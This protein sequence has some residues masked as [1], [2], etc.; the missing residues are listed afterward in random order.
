MGKHIT[1]LITGL[2]KGGAETMLY[3]L[4]CN[5][6]DGSV[7]NE[8][9]SL[10]CSHYYEPLIRTLGVKIT[11]VHIKAHPIRSLKRIIR[12][13]KSADTVY[14]WMY[15]A[16]LLGYCIG[17]LVHVPNIVWSIHHSNLDPEFNKKST[18]AI[19]KICASLSHNVKHIVYAGN[20][21][22]T[23]HEA[24][25]YDKSRGEC[26]DNGCDIE[27]YKHIEDARGSLIEE[28]SID[29]DCQII[30]SIARSHPIK[31]I[32][33][34]I[35]AFGEVHMK[36]EKAIAVLCGNGVDNENVQLMDL[37]RL[38]KLIVGKDIFFLGLR[39]DIPRLL[40][41]SDI[42]VLH[43]RS[44]AFPVTLIQAMLCECIC[45]STDVGDARIMLD[46]EEYITPAGDS[47]KMSKK[48][49]ALLNLSEKEKKIIRDANRQRGVDKYDI[50]KVVAKYQALFNE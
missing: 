37:A 22:K 13:L 19:N 1:H 3:Q 44:E 36:N 25:G 27:Q 9:I 18:L 48:I 46:Q 34:F 39:D 41:A 31:D 4:L 38:N 26:I 50:R 30:L 17:K 2:G 14:C 43:S 42:Y 15:H 12:E 23:I 28:L 7:N 49:G 16:N 20:L 32:P 47:E 24:M 6:C 40:S 11:E 29:E 10:C 5:T 35:N 21:T 33:T 45:L 8:V